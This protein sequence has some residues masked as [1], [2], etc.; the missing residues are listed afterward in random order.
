ME[1]GATA[2]VPSSYYLYSTSDVIAN[3]QDIWFI[4]RLYC[5]T[6]IFSPM[7]FHGIYLLL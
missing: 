1:E 7:F 4:E 5:I 2:V 6:A 3:I